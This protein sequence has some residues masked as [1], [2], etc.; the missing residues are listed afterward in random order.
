MPTLPKNTSR[1]P[2]DKPRKERKPFEGR[3]WD[4]TGRP[5]NSKKWRRAS[6]RFLESNP[7]CV[8]CAKSGKTK[9]SSITDHIDHE[10]YDFWDEEGWQ[11]LCHRCHNRKS[12][13]EAHKRKR[14]NIVEDDIDK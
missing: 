7:L 4:D 6:K 3:K 2:W 1:R 9:A 14:A 8:M 13:R 5:Y 12:G 10:E 11:A